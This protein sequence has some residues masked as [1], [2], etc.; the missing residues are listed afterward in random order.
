MCSFTKSALYR[1][2]AHSSVASKQ[3]STAE[4]WG[5]GD[6]CARVGPELSRCVHLDSGKVILAAI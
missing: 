6:Q 5:L 3:N 1:F 4:D 2:F